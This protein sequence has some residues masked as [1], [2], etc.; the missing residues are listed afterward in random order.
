MAS[1]SHQGS[2]DRTLPTGHC[3]QPLS[4]TA[5]AS[6]TP[7]IRFILA[8]LLAALD[9][10]ITELIQIDYLAQERH[11]REFGRLRQ[12]YL[13]GPSGSARSPSTRH[14]LDPRPPIGSSN[15]VP[16]FVPAAARPGHQAGDRYGRQH[17][18]RPAD[19]PPGPRQARD[20]QRRRP[21]RSDG[22][23]Q[24]VCI[25]SRASACTS[26][27]AAEYATAVDIASEDPFHRSTRSTSR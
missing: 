5:H 18:V 9:A 1:C 12:Q 6:F 17:I 7:A 11:A 4:P 10:I 20:S 27:S 3:P 25:N 21:R 13:P 8:H 22:R 15:V 19:P 24:R 2:R 16:G 26:R 23:E 14:E